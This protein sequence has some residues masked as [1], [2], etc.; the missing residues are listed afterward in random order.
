MST[1]VGRFC[2]AR[3]VLALFVLVVSVGLADSLNPSTIAP[4]LYLAIE[5]SARRV[6]AFA[7]GVFAVSAVGGI[8]LVAGPGQALVSA[9]PRPHGRTTHLIELGAGAVALAAAVALWLGRARVARHLERLERPVRRSAFLLGAGIMA[10]EL[11]TALPYFGALAAIVGSGRPIATQIVL[12]V[13]FNGA[14]VLPLVAIAAIRAV[15]GAEGERIARRLRTQLVR[16]GAALAPAVV[17]LAG[18]VL[19]AVGAA[20]LGRESPDG[21]AVFASSCSGCHSVDGGA[22]RTPGGDLTGYRLTAAEIASFAAVMPVH[23]RLS[24][25]EIRAVAAYVAARER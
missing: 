5:G 10:V 15:A 12:V 17:A 3:A 6:V 25:A 13:I 9:V 1:L 11:P 18:L 21:R 2:E 16:H 23:P 8:V 7:A 4:A 14:F 20:G 24:A 19:L 22:A